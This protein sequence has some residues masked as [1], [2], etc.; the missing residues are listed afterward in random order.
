MCVSRLVGTVTTIHGCI[1]RL[2]LVTA[3]STLGC[4]SEMGRMVAVPII[5]RRQE[6]L[7]TTRKPGNSPPPPP[8]PPWSSSSS[9]L[10]VLYASI[11]ASEKECVDLHISLHDY[12]YIA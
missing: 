8:L 9:S 7:L 1:C 12:L 10:Y 6:E 4:G 11:C 3:Y 2:G 5:R